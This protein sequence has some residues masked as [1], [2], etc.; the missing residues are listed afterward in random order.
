[1]FK[2]TRN[3]KCRAF[4]G[5]VNLTRELQSSV[6]CDKG[7]ANIRSANISFTGG[8]TIADSGNGFGVF[9]ADEAVLVQGSAANN[10]V[11]NMDTVAAGSIATLPAQVTTA[12]ASPTIHMRAF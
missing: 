10:R 4:S 8:A 1:M 2:G 7:G 11:F 9:T 12:A 5:A 3:R 6:S